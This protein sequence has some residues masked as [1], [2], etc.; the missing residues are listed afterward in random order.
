MMPISIRFE[1]SE[2]GETDA[3]VLVSSFRPSRPLLPPAYPI[4]EIRGTWAR[5]REMR[6][7]WQERTLESILAASTSFHTKEKKEGRKKRQQAKNFKMASD[8][9]AI[10]LESLS[11]CVAT[12][13]AT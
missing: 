7:G 1:G 8:F 5:G 4:T 2:A 11:F 12:Q 13:H 6:A 9:A 3:A 10:A